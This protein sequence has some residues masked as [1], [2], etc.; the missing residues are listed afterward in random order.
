MEQMFQR[1]CLTKIFYMFYSS[2]PPTLKHNV[3][4]WS[5]DQTTSAHSLS[6]SERK[7]TEISTCG[8]VFYII[9]INKGSCVFIWLTPSVPL[10][11]CKLFFSQVHHI[12][13]F[14]LFICE[15][16]R[17]QYYLNTVIVKSN[18]QLICF[19]KIV[20]KL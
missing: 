4:I 1:Q 18:W 10:F 14:F 2:E 11:H 17:L 13:L 16:D 5:E 9:Q 7:D 20:A 12:F 6:D 15:Q 19:T 8:F 3:N